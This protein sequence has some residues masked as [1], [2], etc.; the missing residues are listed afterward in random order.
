MTPTPATFLAAE[1][2]TR[3]IPEKYESARDTA[4]TSGN[5]PTQVRA[6]EAVAA[7]VATNPTILTPAKSGEI[8]VAGAFGGAS[9]EPS[10]RLRRALARRS[11]L[12]AAWATLRARGRPNDA[13]ISAA[14]A[15]ANA[16][17]IVAAIETLAITAWLDANL[18][19]LYSTA[20]SL[21]AAVQQEV[22][23][24]VWADAPGLLASLAE[25]TTDPTTEYLRRI[26]T[27]ATTISGHSFDLFGRPTPP[28]IPILSALST[29]VPR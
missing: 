8:A 27:D 2:L 20:H 1:P 6:D 13:A 10:E 12:E 18:G 25:H 9:L 16:Q 3:A 22:V 21:N 23:S 26:A 7:M 17:D 15:N 28:R 11:A 4:G 19:Q 24:A 5:D 14:V 29:V